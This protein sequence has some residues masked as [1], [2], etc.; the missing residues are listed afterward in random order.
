MQAAARA[1]FDQRRRKG[2]ADDIVGQQ[3]RKPRRQRDYLGEKHRRRGARLR[4]AARH[5]R[6]EPPEA[7]LRRDHHQAKK[8]RER[9]EIERGPRFF[10]AQAPGRHERDRPEQRDPRAVQ[11]QPAEFA[12]NHA[13]INKNK[14]NKNRNIHRGGEPSRPPGAM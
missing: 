14:Y 3:G 13:K 1:A 8:K 9:A 10:H 4:L 6:V 12:Q 5:T 2:E 7:E 11:R